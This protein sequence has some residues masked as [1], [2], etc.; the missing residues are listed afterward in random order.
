MGDELTHFSVLD[1][2]SSTSYFLNWAGDFGSGVSLRGGNRVVSDTPSD[3]QI[4][5]EVSGLSITRLLQHEIVPPLS[6]DERPFHCGSTSS[7]S[8]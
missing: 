3:T 8:F 5:I 1:D 6:T 4:E 7:D 2:E